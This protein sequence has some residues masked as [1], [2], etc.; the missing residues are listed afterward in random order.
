VIHCEGRLVVSEG[1]RALQGRIRKAQ[2]RNEK[3]R[4]GS[5]SGE[6]P[7]SGALGALVRLVGTLRAHRGDLKLCQVSPFVKTSCA[8]RTSTA[9]SCIHDTEK[10]ALADSRGGRC[11][12]N[13]TRGPRTPGS[14][15]RPVERPSRL[16][17]GRAQPRRLHVKTTALSGR[18]STLLCAMKPRVVGVCPEEYRSM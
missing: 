6:L 5:R 7:D 14:V 12:S 17:G 9:C 10:D 18:A 8:P 3:I 16:P 2:P 4:P 11:L 15:H 13:R 1:V